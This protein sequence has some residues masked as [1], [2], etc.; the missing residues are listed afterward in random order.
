MCRMNGQFMLEV[1]ALTD[2]LSYIETTCIGDGRACLHPIDGE[3]TADDT[4][5]EARAEDHG[6]VRLIH[7]ALAATK[8]A[9]V[10]LRSELYLAG[11]CADSIAAP[12]KF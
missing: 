9:F 5:C 7:D 4:L 2:Q 1:S 8:S 12:S 3:Q 6:I 10:A 11:D